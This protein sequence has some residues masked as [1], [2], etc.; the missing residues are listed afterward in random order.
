M[1]L[2][3]IHNWKISIYLT[4]SGGPLEC[5]GL[6]VGLASFG[7]QCGASLNHPGVF[8]DIYFYRNWI[9]DNWNGVTMQKSQK[10]SILVFTLFINLIWKLFE[11]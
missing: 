8:V 1:I 10:T 9:I 5:N 2:K 3:K 11:I 4:D 7:A 6:L